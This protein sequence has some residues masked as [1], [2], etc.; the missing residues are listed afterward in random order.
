MSFGSD[1]LTGG[2]GGDYTSWR[3]PIKANSRN[4][5]RPQVEVKHCR[6]WFREWSLF[7]GVFAAIF[8]I[9]M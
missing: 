2:M 9:F 4:S 7:A 1:S 6:A 3:R 8:Q 5:T